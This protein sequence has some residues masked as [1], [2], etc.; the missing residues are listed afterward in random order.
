MFYK[1]L[2]WNLSQTEQLASCYFTSKGGNKQHCIRNDIDRDGN[3]SE[4]SY[5]TFHSQYP[6]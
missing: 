2:Y 6:D 5:F 1:E 4:I 3:C